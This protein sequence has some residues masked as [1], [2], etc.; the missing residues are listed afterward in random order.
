MTLA[1]EIKSFIEG[2]VETSEEVLN[3]YATDASLFFVK[4]AL[5]VFPKTTEDIKKLVT[6]VSEEKKKGRDIS[7]T[8]RAAGTDMTG[9]P[10]T[11]SIVLVFT[12]YLNHLLE[13]G[14]DYAIVEP[15][16]YYRDFEKETLKHNL[17]MPSYPASREICAI[18][19]IV[20]N[21]AG[22][23]KTLSYGKTAKYVDTIYMVLA[24]GNEYA[25][26]KMTEKEL[27]KKMSLKS[28]EGKVYKQ[29]FE[30]INQNYETVKNARPDVTKNSSGYALWDVYDKE[31]GVFDLAKLLV[32]SQGTFGIFTKIKFNLVHPPKTSKLLLIF[33]K[34][35]SSVGE[36]S[37]IILPMHP[38]TLECYDEKTFKLALKYFP[39]ILHKIHRNIIRIILKTLPEF[40]IILLMGSLPKLI[41][42]A[43]FTG[44]TE[45]EVM[46][47]VHTA[48]EALE[49]KL[50]NKIR[51][52]IAYSEEEARE[53]W[54]IRRES[55][56][57]LRQ[58]ANKNM[59]TA[60]FI[61]DFSV[62]ATKLPEFLP[63]LYEIL[64]KYKILY[65]FAGHIGDGNFHIIPLMNLE[66]PKSKKIVDELSR[67][68]FD[69]TFTYNGTTSAE[70]N[71]GIIRTPYLRQQ[72]GDEVYSLFEKTKQIFDP[73]NIFNPGKRSM[74]PL[75]MPETTGKLKKINL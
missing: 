44:E 21:N 55:F 34:D 70:H 53:F 71:D 54:V 26:S 43:E 72:Y 65:T 75:S 69:L 40:W 68:V 29:L 5:V 63:K 18:G 50:G 32:G 46:Q 74:V 20:A 58:H 67:E 61:E 14:D 39:E 48:K 36:L 45:E 2:D 12:K 37:R 51:T 7:L 33:L 73:L 8:A 59:N 52:R 64:G 62:R 66:D 24:D 19:G 9:G 35:F 11:E 16:M 13:I 28:F 47:K 57:L 22:G 31:A 15:G 25:F 42:L 49:K 60:C 1:E 30:L 6:F 3:Q 10:L 4:P 17:F 56:N 41:V 23:E 38:E 27:K